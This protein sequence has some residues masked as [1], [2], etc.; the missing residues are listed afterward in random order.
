VVCPLDGGDGWEERGIGNGND[1]V[2]DHVILVAIV[3]ELDR[4]F[5]VVRGIDVD[6]G[7][8]MVGKDVGG[9]VGGV[10]VGYEMG[11][12]LGL[13]FGAHDGSVRARQVLQLGLFEDRYVLYHI[14]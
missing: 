9:G 4:C 13:E 2:V 14:N 10:N 8:V 6:F 1:V 11:R 7:R 5:A 12:G 3:I